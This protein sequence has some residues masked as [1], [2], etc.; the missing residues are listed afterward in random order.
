MAQVSCCTQIC[1]PGLH[2]NMVENDICI[3]YI[4]LAPTTHIDK[5]PKNVLWEISKPYKRLN[6][7]MNYFHKSLWHSKVK[8]ELNKPSCL[9]S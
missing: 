9:T 6:S 2:L 3:F 5:E 7:I 8:Q 4:F 1:I